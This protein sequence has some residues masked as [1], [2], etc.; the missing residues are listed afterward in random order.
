M[1]PDQSLST[2]QLEK[3]FSLELVAA[4][5][6]VSDPV[7]ACFDENGRMFVAEF[8]AYP[9]AK[10]KDQIL[11]AGTGRTET[12][13]I[14]LLEDT[15]GDGVMDRSTVF[16]DKLDWP[17]SVAAY[18][19]GLFVI[20]P[21]E[22]FYLKDTDGDGKADVK[23][24]VFSHLGRR[25]VQGLA[26]NM[27]WG[28]DNRI[29]VAGGSNGG[30]LHRRG[31]KVLS[32][33]RSD[34]VFNPKT[35]EVARASGGIQFGHSLDDWGNRFLC[36]NNVH[37]MHVVF[38]EQYLNR[39]PFCTVAGPVRMIASDGAAAPVFRR[40]P[41]EPWRIVRT[42]R[43][44]KD[45]QYQHLPDTERVPGG[46]FTSAAGVTIYRGSAYPEEFRGNA[47]VGD[48]GSNLIHRKT[49][50]PHNATFRADRADPNTEFVTSIDTW[51][52]PVNYV[53]AP[54]GTL[55]V[56]DMYRE[57][58]E[59]P[60]SIPEDI[61]AHL[62]LESGNDRGRIYRLVAP[63]MKRIKPP[64]LGE[65]GLDQLVSNLASENSWN[66]ETAQRLLWERQNQAA[67]PLIIKL[68]E[69]TRVPQ[70]RLHALY[71]LQGLGG[72]TPKLIQAALNDPHP[73][74]R[75]HAVR[76]AEPL[77]AGNAALA[78]AVIER[79]N[80]TD[81]RTRFQSVL[82]LGSMPENLALRGLVSAA[83]HIGSDPDM[84]AAYLLSVGDKGIPLLTLLLKDADLQQQPHSPALLEGIV[85]MVSS[86]PEPMV[87]EQLL[88]LVTA[89]AKSLQL[90]SQL[91]QAIG[92]GSVRRGQSLVKVINEL[93]ADGETRIRIQELFT[94]AAET[95]VNPGENNSARH[96][97]INILALAPWSFAGP[98]FESLLSPQYPQEIQAAAVAA[99]RPVTDP[100]VAPLLMA[101]WRRLTPAARGATTEVMLA[102]EDRTE[103]L[104]EAL[105][106]GT[107]QRSEFDWNRIRTLTKHSEERIRRRAAH[108]LEGVESTDR[109]KVVRDYQIALELT[110][111]P[112]RG[113][114]IYQQK[115]SI[116]HK[117]GDTGHQ[118]G[119]DMT[120]VQNKPPADLLASILNPNLEMQSSYTTYTVTTHDGQIYTGMIAAETDSS[121]TLRRAEAKE[122][123]VLR[124]QIDELIANGQSL[125]PEGLERDINPRQMADLIAFIKGIGSTSSK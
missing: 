100:A 119:P 28:L 58:I 125:M 47:F 53:N 25:N 21:P 106:N 85:E 66:R 64:R 15:D 8:H 16:A 2:F 39:N 102:R 1:E 89:S 50:Q 26:N 95:A 78:H 90:R 65:V 109:A 14:R 20:D 51:F 3:G 42:Q 52:R 35:E 76:L 123:T 71:T 30:D 97:A 46:F 31:E 17:L 112:E 117:L 110:G 40:S 84:R 124:S 120:S 22:V 122:D 91:V 88:E 80:D 96:A 86:R 105:E 34:W 54:D 7:D 37:I 48:V 75:Q 87:A 29:W 77:L 118:V 67:V 38:E 69:T 93:P 107:I 6:L 44:N 9:Y 63:G 83:P 68:F 116:C 121:L 32:L 60:I 24:T 19:G 41:I 82:A 33:G 43:R 94:H 27:K 114:L 99:L 115:C 72:L 74:V 92:R 13:I 61:R 18:N 12:G 10:E 101:S 104:L 23:E 45:P 98:A 103:K 79:A 11:P 5:P 73:G 57:T 113:K 111:N 49:L 56:L 70:G 108:L 59:H 4:E 62:D 36:S 55:Y 81:Y